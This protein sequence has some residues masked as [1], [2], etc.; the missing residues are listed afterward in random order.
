MLYCV[1]IA[2]KQF[3]FAKCSWLL[4][5]PGGV[6]G[7]NPAA[8]S[9]PKTSWG[10][11]GCHEN[12]STHEMGSG[13]C[14]SGLAPIMP[15]LGTRVLVCKSPLCQAPSAGVRP[16]KRG[17]SLVGW[18]GAVA[19]RGWPSWVCKAVIPP[20]HPVLAPRCSLGEG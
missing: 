6:C 5:L 8:Y 9:T 3:G 2:L 12:V 16:Q 17:K 15:C 11:S 14:R 13:F 10:F 4:L 18:G 20:S 7:G 19:F 1:H